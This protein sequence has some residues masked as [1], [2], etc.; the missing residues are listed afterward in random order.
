MTTFQTEYP[1]ELATEALLQP[2]DKLVVA[3]DAAGLFAVARYNP[4]GSLD[5][6]FGSGGTVLVESLP[7]ISGVALA[8][9]P[10]GKL[11]IAGTNYRAT[12]DVFT[13]RGFGLMRLAAD[14]SA[15]TTFAPCP[16]VS[17]SVGSSEE[18]TD[19]LVQPDGR[20]VVL[21]E[22]EAARFG[23][24]STPACQNA[25][26][27]RL[28]IR[29]ATN[30][31]GDLLKWKWKGSPVAGGDFGDP[32][33]DTG[34]TFCVLDQASTAPRLRIGSP[35]MQFDW[36]AATGGFLFR[37]SS[38]NDFPF[39]KAK[40]QAVASGKGKIQLT[41]KGEYLHAY[42]PLTTPVTVRLVRDDAAQCWEATFSDAV[43]NTSERFS[44][45]T[46]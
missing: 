6:S 29:N 40:L 30:P 4:D 9:Q 32:T 13:T 41:A 42:L 15:D 44:A 31:D 19:V 34:Y 24:P 28:K 39:A 37:T 11:V 23:T 1:Y 33:A 14:G 18:V 27:G 12:E 45:K 3:G 36:S 7:V 5:P 22:L 38:D 16:Q 43:R 25:A 20:I 2:D 8:R 17:T 21:G 26:S 10:D 46:D 35:L